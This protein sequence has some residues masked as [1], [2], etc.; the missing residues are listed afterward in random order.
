VLLRT[1]RF[2]EIKTC[3]P[4]EEVGAYNLLTFCGV[5]LVKTEYQSAESQVA[6]DR[7]NQNFITV[8]KK[9]TFPTIRQS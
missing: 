7:I 8:S 3:E 2:L 1:L 5:P 4:T 6:F 9:K